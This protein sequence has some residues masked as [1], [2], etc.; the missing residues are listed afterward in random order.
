MFQR[1]SDNLFVERVK[2][3][4]TKKVITF[5]GKT[6][7]IV[8]QKILEWNRQQE[9]GLT[10]SEALDLW[11][12]RKEKEVSYKT[13]EGYKAPAGR[14]REA[15]GEDS[16]RDIT[17]AQVQAFVNG[18]AARGYKRTTVQRPLDVL[19]MLFDFLITMEGSSVKFN[20]CTG[21]RLPKGL[22]QDSR[23][24][25]PR[26]AIEIIK[27]SLGHPF[28]LYPFFIM[29]TGMRDGEALAITDQDIRDGKI[30]VSK[31][32]SWQTNKPVIKDPKTENG[33]REVILL[34][35]LKA[36]LPKRFKGY[37]F[38]ADGGKTPLTNTQ[39]RSRWNGYCRDVGLAEAETQT[40]RSPGANKRIY[41]KTVW[42]NTI[43]PYQLRHEFA[44]MCFD[45]GLD[46]ADTADLMGHSDESTA[47]RWY[48]HVQDLRREKSAD[49][50]EEFISR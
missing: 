22:R 19:R 21:V 9:F 8:N 28:G 42:H 17:P 29:Y 5:T 32:V 30:F 15:F 16:I 27:N 4:G 7:A 38:S 50:L 35:P 6:K 2:I 31:N 37:L 40:H 23:D 34:S 44:T 1:K 43:V 14:I 10:V 46:P 3:P 11:L 13:Y 39:F 12:A 25:A 36:A 41:T 48:T 49:K 18:I 20:P 24:L 26:E 45:A 33:I 47:R